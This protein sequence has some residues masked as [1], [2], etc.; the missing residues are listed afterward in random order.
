M[1]STQA[2]DLRAPRVA[3]VL[4][5]LSLVVA[6]VVVAMALT[7]DTSPAF[8]AFFVAFALAI[9]A[10][11]AATVLSRATTGA[12]GA[13]E[14]RNRFS[15][16]RLQP[17]EVDRVVVGGQG[18]L[19]GLRRL[20]LLLTDGTTLPLVAT[21]VPPLFGARRRLEEQ[22]EQVRR[23]IGDPHHPRPTLQRSGR[24]SRRGAARSAVGE[25]HPQAEGD[26]HATGDPLDG[27]P[28]PV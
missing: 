2:V 5:G 17:A 16:R 25:D 4:Y 18:G 28:C 11:N 7:M 3:V 9:C 23:W 22:A 10:H 13:L 8:T 20:D 1:T 12:D 6:A 21:E 27:D 26:E 14:V 19:G 24:A 15:T